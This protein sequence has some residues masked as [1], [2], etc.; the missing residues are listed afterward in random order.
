MEGS[1]AAESHCCTGE[2][3]RNSGKKSRMFDNKNIE[4]HNPAIT[5]CF[6]IFL[7]DDKFQA[8]CWLFLVKGTIISFSYPCDRSFESVI[9]ENR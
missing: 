4:T 8:D 2:N 7:A 9:S 6:V 3:Y 1:L 5:Q